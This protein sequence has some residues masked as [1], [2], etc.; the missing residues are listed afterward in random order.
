[1]FDCMDVRAASTGAKLAWA[2]SPSTAMIVV[3]RAEAGYRIRSMW[4]TK[5]ARD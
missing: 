4:Q 5:A 2:E 1:M 3:V